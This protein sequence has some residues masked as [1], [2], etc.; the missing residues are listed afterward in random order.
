MV[1]LLHYLKYGGFE[2]RNPSEK[3]NSAFYLRQNP[4]V[5]AAGRNPLVHYSLYGKK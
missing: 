1:P 4:D 2:G 5:K 3:L